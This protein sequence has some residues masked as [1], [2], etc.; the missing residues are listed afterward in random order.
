MKECPGLTN[1]YKAA[2]GAAVQRSAKLS[3]A[4]NFGFC[5]MF[6]IDLQRTKAAA[7]QRLLTAAEPQPKKDV[8]WNRSVP[9][10]G[11]VG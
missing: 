11:S 8:D 3:R 6:L 9:I 5:R 2:P 10:R 4:L 1:C 7:T